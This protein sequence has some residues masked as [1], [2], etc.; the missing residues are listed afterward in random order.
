MLLLLRESYRARV[1]RVVRLWKNAPCPK[2]TPLSC[3]DHFIRNST[4]RLSRND[5]SGLQV[6][7]GQALLRKVLFACRLKAA[8]FNECTNMEVRFRRSRQAFASQSGS[9]LA[10]EAASRLPGRRI[11]LGYLAFVNDIIFDIK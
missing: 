9:A 2:T 11:E 4:W 7:P 5:F 10:A 3:S 6:Q 1:R 8:S